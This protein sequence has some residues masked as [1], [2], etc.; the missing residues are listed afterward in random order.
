MWHLSA[1]AVREMA[2]RDRACRTCHRWIEREERCAVAQRVITCSE[3]E[4]VVPYRY[5]P[6]CAPADARTVR[7]A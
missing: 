6:A 2:K 4:I 3:G 7:A 1:E 5:H